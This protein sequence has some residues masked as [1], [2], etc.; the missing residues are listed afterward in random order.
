VR[1]LDVAPTILGAVGVERPILF[2]GA[3]L[4]HY[5]AG[6]PAPAPYAI[7]VLEEGGTSIRT[8]EWK[9]IR[10]SLF[11]LSKDPGETED[12]AA[13]FPGTSEKLRLIKLELVTEGPSIGAVDATISPE[14]R[15]RLESLGYFE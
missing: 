1:L 13:R 9:R 5:A 14:L 11:D 8:P 6:G 10:R 4:T 7:S 12:V 2:Q 15:E 3:D